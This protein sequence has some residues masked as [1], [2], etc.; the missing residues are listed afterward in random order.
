M[1]WVCVNS[2]YSDGTFY[3]RWVSNGSNKEVDDYIQG[4]LFFAM[5]VMAR[6]GFP[7]KE[8]ANKWGREHEGV[9][10]E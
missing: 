2:Y 4:Q 10:L 1:K 9:F 3:S 5:T 7:E 6:H 8:D